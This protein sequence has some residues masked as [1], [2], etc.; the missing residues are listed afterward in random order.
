MYYVLYTMYY[1]PCTMYYVC[2]SRILSS[3][4]QHSDVVPIQQDLIQLGDLS[5]LW[6]GL[7]KREDMITYV[8]LFSSCPKSW[9]N[10]TLPPPKKKNLQCTLDYLNLDYPDL[11][12]EQKGAGYLQKWA[13][14]S[15]SEVLSIA[16]TTKPWLL[17]EG[18]CRSKVSLLFRIA[19][20][21]S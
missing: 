2:C 9:T 7:T 17:A 14:P 20:L 16:L 6:C 11:K 10:Y 1:V 12:P 18:A 4:Y 13:C 3:R 15:C 5:P 21:A 19:R 8:R